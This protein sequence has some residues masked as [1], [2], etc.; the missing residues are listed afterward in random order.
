MALEMVQVR[1][2]R[3]HDVDIIALRHQLL[4]DTDVELAFR[5]ELLACCILS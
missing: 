4:L 1:W 2:Y 3:G 5:F